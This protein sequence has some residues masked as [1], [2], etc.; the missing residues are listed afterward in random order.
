M[1]ELRIR[2][3]RLN[4]NEPAQSVREI[5]AEALEIVDPDQRARF[6]AQVCG[7][8]TGLRREVDELLRAEADAGRFL[9][10]QP[11][12]ACCCQ[13]KAFPWAQLGW[14]RCFRQMESKLPPQD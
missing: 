11:G 6:L 8:N 3:D 9:P 14:Q 2:I 12:A 10:D 7:S 5:F 4:Q 13:N 1:W